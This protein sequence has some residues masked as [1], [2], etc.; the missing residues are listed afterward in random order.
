M[1]DVASYVQAADI[2]VSMGGYNSVCELLSLGKP[3]LIVPRTF[4]RREQLI[5]AE[6]LD[7]LGL[8]R[9][10]DPA[11]VGPHRLLAEMQAL[12]EQPPQPQRLPMRGLPGAADEIEALLREP[13][14]DQVLALPSP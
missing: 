1:D 14:A 2:V 6:A 9:M 5:R 3:A 12:L 7:R 8:L 10:I 13:R 4:P 11:D